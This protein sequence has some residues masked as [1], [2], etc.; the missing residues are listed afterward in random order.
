MLRR[1]RLA[2]LVGVVAAAAAVPARADHPPAAAA[3]PHAA[4]APAP[5]AAPCAPATRKIQCVEYVPENYT[6]TRTCYRYECRQEKCTAYRCEYVPETRTKTVCCVRYV[7]EVC[8]EVRTVCEMVRTCEERTVMKPCWTT[9]QETCMVTRKVD[10][11]HWECRE[12]EAHGIHALCHR[13]RHRH[14]CCPPC[15]P[16]RTR[17][18]WVPCWVCEQVPVTRCKK[19]CTMVPHKCM[20]NV[21][22]PVTRQVTCQVTRC[23]CVTEQKVVTYTCCVARQV[24]YETCRTVRVCVPYQETVTCCRMVPRCVTREVPCCVAECCT[25]CCCEAPRCHRRHSFT[26]RHR[27]GCDSCCSTSSC[28][29]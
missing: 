3:A 19:V 6:T 9:V 1:L 7:P 13:I 20:V 18:C 24:P 26:H 21:C 11:G 16:T 17:K 5:A 10:R 22:R 14:D 8:T 28:C 25:P 27:G 15:P 2:C 23:K 12:E 4:A 29:H